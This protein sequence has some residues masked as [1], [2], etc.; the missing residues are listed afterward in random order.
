MEVSARYVGIISCVAR[1]PTLLTRHASPPGYFNVFNSW[2]S[3]SLLQNSISAFGL[4]VCSFILSRRVIEGEMDVGN[5]VA[6]V[7][8][9]NQLYSP[10]NQISSL[11]RRVM[12]NAVGEL[13]GR[14]CDRSQCRPADRYNLPPHQTPSS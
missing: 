12:N 3:L 8:Y 10:L 5:Y 2:Q 14:G 11:Y 7:S 9:L 1:Y 4:L 6:F 13:A